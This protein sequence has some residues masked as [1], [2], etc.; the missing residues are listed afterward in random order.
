MRERNARDHHEALVTLDAQDA[1]VVD[2]DHVGG[3]RLGPE[4]LCLRYVR[5][6]ER[7]SSLT[8]RRNIL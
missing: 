8:L 4:Q 1:A 6:S 3:D 7:I 2:E 5:R